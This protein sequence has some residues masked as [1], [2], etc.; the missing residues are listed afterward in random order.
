MIAVLAA[1]SGIVALL[2]Y[3]GNQKQQ[4]WQQY[5]Q[6]LEQWNNFSPPS[7]SKGSR[8]VT[9]RGLDRIDFESGLVSANPQTDRQWDLLFGCWPEGYE[10]LRALEGVSWSELGVANLDAIKYREIRDAKYKAQKSPAT[11]YNDLYY[12]HKSNVPGKGYI[13]FVKTP[14]GNIAKLQITGYDIVDNNPLVCRN[15]RMKYELF[16]VKSDPPKPISPS[17]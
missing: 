14:E 17:Q 13:F 9:L 2:N 6:E 1:G 4:E 11:G 15:M 10:S 8:E 7:L 5:Q 3:Y 16:P 12:A